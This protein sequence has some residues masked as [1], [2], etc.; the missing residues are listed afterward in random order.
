MNDDLNL[1]ITYISKD[2]RMHKTVLQVEHGMNI[3]KWDNVLD[4]YNEP[5]INKTILDA[6]P[7]HVSNHIHRIS[8]IESAFDVTV[9]KQQ[10]ELPPK[11][12]Y[13]YVFKTGVCDE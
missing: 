9:V 4:Y 3:D 5:E 13:K 2:Y 6:L 12:T 11:V 10:I 1:I 7:L 8:N